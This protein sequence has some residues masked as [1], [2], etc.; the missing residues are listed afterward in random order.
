MT[1]FMDK[2][3]HQPRGFRNP[4]GS[5]KKAADL[6][7]AGQLWGNPIVFSEHKIHVYGL[8]LRNWSQVYIEF[9]DERIVIVRPKTQVRRDDK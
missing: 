6:W 7:L 4:H 8:Y 9:T 1:D 2:F 3:Y 5:A